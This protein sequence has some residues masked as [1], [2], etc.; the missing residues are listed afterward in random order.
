MRQRRAPCSVPGFPAWARALAALLA[1]TVAGPAGAG[2]L[3]PILA[4]YDAIPGQALILAMR[5]TGRERPPSRVT[6]RFPDG[7]EVPGEVAA[8]RLLPPESGRQSWLTP[9]ARWEV[10]APDE[11][12]GAFDRL[13]WFILAELPDGVIGQELWL[14]GRP[15]ALR[16]LSRPALLAARL[17]FEA[18]G[19]AGPM[20]DPWASPLPEDWR[21]RP[22]L[23]ELLEP[24]RSDPLRRWRARLAVR[25]LHP[26]PDRGVGAITPEQLRSGLVEASARVG[27]LAERL[28]GAV[29]DLTEARWRVG[30]A[31]LW[32]ADPGLSLRVRHA[33][34]GGGVFEVEA[35]AG[36]RVVAPVWAA[37]ARRA[38]V[39]LEIL[40]D[41]R[42]PAESRVRRG[43]EWLAGLS[44]AALW[45][46]DDGGP[47]RGARIGAMTLLA[48]DTTA[49]ELMGETVTRPSLLRTRAMTVLRGGTPGANRA[50]Y[51]LGG[52]DRW[53]S[54]EGG[55]VRAEPPGVVIGPAWGDASM[56][57]WLGAGESGLIGAPEERFAGLVSARPGPAGGLEW[58]VFIRLDGIGEASGERV[59]LWIGPYGQSRGVLTLDGDGGM[60]LHRFREW[61]EGLG[62][63]RLVGSVREGA[64]VRIELVLPTGAVDPEGM[65]HLGL[66][67]VDKAG[68]RWSWPR[69]MLPWQ[70]E[71]GRR[72]IDTSAWMGR[73]NP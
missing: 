36:E 65:L 31:R 51:R 67:R 32:A 10:L 73:L 20:L 56:E 59:R 17:G 60:D 7:R 57:R 47:G 53:L 48:G 25:G 39:L 12:R 33:L 14:D 15:I 5:P 13:A 4:S 58:T 11:V 23:N 35:G 64:G 8:V 21:D 50:G 46:V 6:L 26:E 42:D 28:L 38:D 24:A 2:P 40:L 52:R 29:S 3:E 70:I 19:G 37:D 61:G 43:E 16:W 45:V 68:N 63:A 49:I 41:E 18:E 69:A 66:E 27:P 1:I 71:P 62:E 30:L 9:G 22:D 72:V 44:D 54:V 55:A 34:A